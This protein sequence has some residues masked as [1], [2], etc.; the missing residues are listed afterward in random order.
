MSRGRKNSMEAVGLPKPL[1][2]WLSQRGWHLHA[3][4]LAMLEQA[5]RGTSALLVA[6]TGSGKTLS[7]FLPVLA[8]LVEHPHTGIHTLYISP[9]KALAQDIHRNLL[10]PIEEMQ[11]PVTVETL[12]GDTPSHKRARMKKKM[13]AI[14]LTTPESLTRLLS[15][16]DSFKQFAGLKNIIIDEIHAFAANKRGEQMTLAMARLARIAPEARRIGLSA[17]VADPEAL[18]E[19]LARP[20]EITEIIRA[21]DKKPPVIRILQGSKPLPLAGHFPRHAVNEILA[22]IAAHK[23][24]IIFVNTRSQAEL[25]FQ[26][27]WER[28]TENLPIGLHHGS[29]TKDK[30]LKVEAAMAAGVLRGVIATAALDL[31]IDWGNVELV[32]QIGAPK[33]ISRLLQ[34]IGRSNH[35]P[36]LASEAVLVPTNCLEAVECAAALNAIEAR[37][38]DDAPPSRQGSLDVLAQHL[39]TMACAEPFL[40]DALYAEILHAYPYAHLPRPVFDAVLRYVMNGGYALKSYERFQ[41]LVLLEDGRIAPSAPR[42]AQRHRMNLG[43][44]VES[45]KLKV[46]RVTSKSGGRRRRGGGGVPLGEVEERLV[47]GMVPGDCFIFGGQALEFLG[48]REMRVE[49]QPARADKPK[50][51][52]FFGGRMPMSSHLAEGVR[53]LMHHREE[54]QQLPAQV[55]RWLELQEERSQLPPEEGLLVETFPRARM[56]YLVT[57]PF[58]G[59]PAHQALGLLVSG[60]ME[61]MGLRPLGFCINDYGLA[62]WSLKPLTTEDIEQLFSP[63]LLQT[64]LEQWLGD[65]NMLKRNFRTTAVIAGLIERR[66][67]GEQK[68]GKALTVSTDLIYDVLNQYEPDHIL[69]LS[70]RL[71]T[72]R[73]QIDLPRLRHCLERVKEKLVHR[74]LPRVSPLAIPVM[75]ESFSERVEGEAIEDVLSRYASIDARADMLMKEATRKGRASKE[76]LPVTALEWL[77]DHIK[78]PRAFP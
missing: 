38:R 51:P 21:E 44:I 72:E 9:L 3:H 75:L 40:P 69:L 42:V 50:I 29:L 71:D 65:S 63:D 4:Q 22:L 59:R 66:M 58:E 47:T 77:P 13:P 19:W 31:G 53:H 54:A 17:T 64:E 26:T 20:D 39:V 28:N 15:Y 60:R 57:Y 34:R 33:G 73:E 2:D 56:H 16:G 41:K 1:A 55:H 70:N 49:V 36:D 30:R 43:T 6:P 78:P 37:Q 76:E 5:R 74:A 11:L 61:R 14:L 27:L 46:V 10:K 48:I 68:R 62:L 52:A 8:D 12:T 24:S 67:P 18:A 35:R 25:L 23:S 7:G 32:M 45:E